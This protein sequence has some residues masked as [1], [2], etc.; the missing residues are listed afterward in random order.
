M[1]HHNISSYKVRTC[2]SEKTNNDR[3]KVKPRKH[4]MRGK[5]RR[6]KLPLAGRKNKCLEKES[7]ADNLRQQI[8]IV[9][10]HIWLKW[11]LFRVWTHMRLY[12]P[13]TLFPRYS[14]IVPTG[15]GATVPGR[16]GPASRGGVLSPQV[17]ALAAALHCPT[18]VYWVSAESGS[19]A[20]SE[21]KGTPPFS[22][23]SWKVWRV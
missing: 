20:E 13:Q 16:K 1:K 18:N 22:L 10:Q 21:I 17:A 4:R 2:W 5:E 7:V 3:K 19:G 8:W 23:L 9:R 15:S 12:L 6:T 11:T 14:N